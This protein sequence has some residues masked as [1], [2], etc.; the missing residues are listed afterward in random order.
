MTLL[1]H[2]MDMEIYDVYTRYRQADLFL[3]R[4]INDLNS[5]LKM[6]ETLQK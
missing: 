5:S 6:N 1:L 4:E 2:M 3:F